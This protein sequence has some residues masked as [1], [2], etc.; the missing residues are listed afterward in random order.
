MVRNTMNLRGLSAVFSL[1]ATLSL[2]H[3]ASAQPTEPAN[4]PSEAPG[5][6]GSATSL[7]Q[8]SKTLLAQVAAARTKVTTLVAQFEQVRRIGL[9][10]TDVTSRGK[11][12]LQRPNRLRWELLAPDSITYWVGPEG[13]S[14]ASDSSSANVDRASAGPLGAIMNDLLVFLAGDVASLHKRYELT[15]KQQDKQIHIEAVPKDPATKKVVQHVRI[16]MAS[17]LVTPVQ[18]LVQETE[19]EFVKI[20]F[21]DVKRNA[22]L[23]PKDMRPKPTA[24]K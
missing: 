5:K 14:F 17:D 23:A 12:A 9:L 15:A 20:R 2:T 1:F 13:F 22:P 24:Q 19:T 6:S 8:Q 3:H 7:K 11:L 16:V 10:A 4:T 21:S 18:V